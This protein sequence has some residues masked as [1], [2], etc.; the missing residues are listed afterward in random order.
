MLGLLSGCS[1]WTEPRRVAVNGSVIA[2]DQL[3][4]KG[5]IRFLPEPGTAGTVTLTSVQAGLYNF[6]NRDGPFP[7]KYKVIVNLELSLD[8][9]A[10]ISRASGATPPMMWEDEVTVPD[11]ETATRHFIWTD[12]EEEETAKDKAPPKSREKPTP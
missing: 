3:V 12:E 11:E 1:R 4:P 8:D 10:K 6:T 5:T 9:L 7:G 2:V